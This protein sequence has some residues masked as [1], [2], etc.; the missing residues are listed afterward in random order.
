MSKFRKKINWR[1]IISLALTAVLLVGSVALVASFV[2]KNT[3]SVGFGQFHRGGIDVKGEHVECKDSLY[4]DFIGA[5]GLTVEPEFEF[6]GTYEVFYYNYE[7]TFI[8]SSGVKSA[9]DKEINL[10]EE[11]SVY[12]RIMI[13]PN[14]SKDIALWDIPGIVKQLKITTLRDQDMNIFDAA[15]GERNKAVNIAYNTD[16]NGEL[17]TPKGIY[18]EDIRGTGYVKYD[19]NNSSEFLVV[20]DEGSASERKDLYVFV[21]GEDDYVHCEYI[22][23]GVNEYKISLASEYYSTGAT[24]IYINYD[25]NNPFELYRL[26]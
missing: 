1:A 15:T 9:G 4:S 22:P 21:V 2:K 13:T 20:F 26:K 19:V 8:K 3:E 14:E 24:A 23:A 12:A 18:F 5:K 10:D 25:M 7:K 11:I 16:E 17:T 6:D